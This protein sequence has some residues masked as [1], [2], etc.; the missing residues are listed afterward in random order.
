MAK[1]RAATKNAAADSGELEVTDS[2]P[3]DNV[4]DILKEGSRKLEELFT[5]YEAA[6]DERKAEVINE[7]ASN[8][9]IL[10]TL[11]EEVVYPALEG[12]GIPEPLLDAARS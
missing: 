8:I 5:K 1:Q 11:R 12:T 3:D 4:I 10:A 6:S 9:T 2:K 7:L